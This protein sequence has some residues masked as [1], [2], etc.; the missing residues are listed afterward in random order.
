MLEKRR[1]LP[2]TK[3]AHETPKST[4]RHRESAPQPW[5]A[6]PATR[7]TC[8]FVSSVSPPTVFWRPGAWPPFP[9][10]NLPQPAPPTPP[11]HLK[12]VPPG[13]LRASGGK[14]IR[15]RRPSPHKSLIF[16]FPRAKTSR[17]APKKA[18]KKFSPVFQEP[19]RPPPV[20]NF[21]RP[22]SPA[23]FLFPRVYPPFRVG[24]ALGK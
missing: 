16:F 2:K 1:P 20:K 7:P 17:G 10:K 23:P 5:P 9:K 12:E 18:K 4:C 11:S 15:P 8:C 14:H 24:L 3:P 21:T 22:K 19:R 6:P 13:K